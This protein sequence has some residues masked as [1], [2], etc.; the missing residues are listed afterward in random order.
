MKTVDFFVTNLGQDHIVLGFPFLKEFN[1]EINWETGVIL[2]TN[3]IFATPKY[4][5]EHQWK[6]WKLDGHLL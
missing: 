2:P 4:L 3:K 6:V 5:W 1:P